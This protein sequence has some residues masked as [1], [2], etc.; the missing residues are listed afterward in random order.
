[1]IKNNCSASMLIS[2]QRTGTFSLLRY[3]FLDFGSSQQIPSGSPHPNFGLFFTFK[4][5]SILFLGKFSFALIGLV[6]Q[7]FFMMLDSL[8]TSF[9]FLFMVEVMVVSEIFILIG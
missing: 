3:F 6:F 8:Y 9:W 5:L 7:S 4:V 1:M 2:F